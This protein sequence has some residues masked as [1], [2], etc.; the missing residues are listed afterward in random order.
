MIKLNLGMEPTDLETER[1]ARLPLA[2]DAFNSHGDN[3]K[4][5]KDLLDDGYQVARA[6]LYE[7]QHGK[8]AFCE[9]NEVTAFRPVEHFRPKKGAQDKVNGSWVTVSTHYW[10]LTWTWENLY[11][12]CQSCNMSGSK[13]SK[14]PITLGTARTIAPTRPIAGSVDPFHYILTDEEPLLLDPRIDSPLDHLE[15]TPVNR[16]QNKSQWRWTV[17]GRDPRG[18]MTVEVLRLKAREDLV[19]RHLVAVRLLWYQI[20]NHILSGRRVDAINCWEDLVSNYI[21]N[22]LQ[23]FRNAAWWAAN[24]LMPKTDRVLHGLRE[25]TIPSV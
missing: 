20:N 12:S 10:W 22:P 21:D 24:S 15:W 13:G 1:K 19:N 23:P 2:I 18:A 4:E 11:F 7:R 14:F 8:C 6:T 17:E 16:F 25:P 9:S 3:H 5:F